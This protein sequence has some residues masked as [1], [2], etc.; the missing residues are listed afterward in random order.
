MPKI[1]PTEFYAVQLRVH[2]FLA[3][4]PLHDVWAVDLPAYRSGITLAE[5]FRRNYQSEIARLPTVAR[6]L[7]RFRLF[8]GRIFRLEA[9][10]R[11]AVAAAFAKRLTPEDR[12]R[13]L[14]P[15]GT[16][17]GLFRVVYRFENE[18]LLEVHNR[19][20]HAAALSALV[21]R[22]DGY[23]F[24]FAV[25]VRQSSWITRFYM[26]LIDPFRE[27]II[28]PALLRSIRATWDQTMRPRDSR[29]AP[30]SVHGD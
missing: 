29:P 5:F 26:G 4:V 16:Q 8:L 15:V 28:Y 3:G 6:A 25:Y 17:E 27:W 19:T 30:V 23:R 7:F 1:S 18:Q 13:S 2:A 24:Y 14:V 10:P 20:V 21:E 11:H 12:A 22:T 9:E